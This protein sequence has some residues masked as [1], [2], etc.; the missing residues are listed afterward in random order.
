MRRYFYTF[1][2][3]FEMCDGLKGEDID[4]KKLNKMSGGGM[5][6]VYNRLLQHDTSLNDLQ[7]LYPT[8]HELV[9]DVSDLKRFKDLYRG[10]ILEGLAR[11][12]VALEKISDI[13]YKVDNTDNNLNNFIKTFNQWADIITG[14]QKSVE[15][16]KKE[17]V[18]LREELHSKL[19]AKK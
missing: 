13:N 8:I 19:N 12:S 18:G 16:L 17:N 9:D 2:R 7:R 6:F 1:M 10:D 3:K 5:D 15:D 11:S 14:L 4:Y